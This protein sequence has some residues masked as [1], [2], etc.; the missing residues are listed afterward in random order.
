MDKII[1]NY[2]KDQD[3]L[4]SLIKEQQ[5][6]IK[7]QTKLINENI[8]LIRNHHENASNKLQAVDERMLKYTHNVEGKIEHQY[9]KIDIRLTSLEEKLC[10]EFLGLK[11]DASTLKNDTRLLKN[12][13][14]EIRR[15]T[16]ESIWAFT[17]H[18]SIK[19]SKW[20]QNQ[21]FNP[22]RWAV[23]YQYLY[24]LYRVLNEFRPN[25]ILE[26][27]LGQSTKMIGQYVESN[28]IVEHIVVE[29]DKEWENFY[30][31]SNELCARTII[32]HMDLVTDIYNNHELLVYSDFDKKLIGKKF[33]FISID[34]PFGGKE[35][36]YARIDTLRIIPDCLK[37]DFVI[38]IDDYNRSGEKEM[39]KELCKILDENDISYS[40]GIYSGAKDTLIIVSPQYSFL[41]TM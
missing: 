27:G 4:I 15:K 34:A 11:N 19:D 25:N 1:M 23:G 40:R 33:D 35:N 38:M 7:E 37:D 28:T 12:R 8:R 16:D 26:L 17:W 5:S 36:K 14:D 18:D 31:N 10:R 24:V 20:L 21:T 2:K 6:I 29:H 41:C 9:A 3:A 13:V 39:V 22:G 30:K 32:E